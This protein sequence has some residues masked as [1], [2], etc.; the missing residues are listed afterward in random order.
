MQIEHLHFNI[1]CLPQY[2]NTQMFISFRQNQLRRPYK[3]ICF[4]AITYVNQRPEVVTCKIIKYTTM[5]QTYDNSVC[6]SFVLMLI[7]FNFENYLI[8][9][10]II[11]YANLLIKFW[12]SYRTTNYTHTHTQTIYI[13]YY[14]I[15]FI[16]FTMGYRPHSD[17]NLSR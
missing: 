10:I 7:F 11:I 4:R 17:T 16:Y 9:F 14:F 12:A 8:V 15:L 6:S 5:K 2:F 1:S 13:F 3:F